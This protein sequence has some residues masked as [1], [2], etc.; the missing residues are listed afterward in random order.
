MNGEGIAIA[1]VTPALVDANGLTFEVFTAGAAS[2]DRLALC[3]HG[4][5]EHAH[6]WR[7]QM[8]P[9]ADL[10]YRVWAPNLRGYGRSS[11]PPRIRDYAIEA[12]LDDVAGLIDASGA[13]EVVLLGHDWGAVI[14][15]YFAM[16]RVRPL[17]RLVIMN[18]PHPVPEK[19]ASPRS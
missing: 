1:A 16:H 9:L 10:G 8:Q 17:S 6:S 15:W 14:A 11:R 4:F 13:R 5:P 12:L 18:V 3:L 19:T 2:A 7:F